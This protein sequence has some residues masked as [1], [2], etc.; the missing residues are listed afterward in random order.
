[1]IPTIPYLQGLFAHFNALFFDGELP[2][3]P[4][5]LS[6]A[7]SYVARC[8]Y[9]R[10]RLLFGREQRYGFC[11]RFST[12][13]DLPEPEVEDTLIHEM[14]HLWIM[15][16]RIPDTSTHGRVFRQW[17]NDIN[18]RYGRHIRISHK[19]T[20]EDAALLTDAQPRKPRIVALVSMKDGRRGIKVLPRVERR[21]KEYRKGVL[22]SG[23]VAEVRF[24]LSDHP[25][26]G[27][28]PSSAALRVYFPPEADIDAA[29]VGA[30][31]LC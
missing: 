3:V 24:F 13:L 29:L 19:L 22:S 10:R 14:I 15:Y 25:F 21:L 28:Y 20:K 18:S 11:I 16:K 4:I 17:M 23:K 5:L 2:D 27:R 31:D 8:E 7:K 9:K 12:R 6:H 1:M 26:F 30:W